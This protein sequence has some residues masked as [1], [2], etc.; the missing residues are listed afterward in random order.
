ML[1]M[2]EECDKMKYRFHKQVSAIMRDAAGEAKDM[3]NNYIGSEHLLLAILKDTTT[4][5]SK[6]LAKQ[7]IYYY[8]LKEDLMVLFEIGRAHV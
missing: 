7:G 4:P 1:L 8:Q 5:M 6:L 2:S 3:G